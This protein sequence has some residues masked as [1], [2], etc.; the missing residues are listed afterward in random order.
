MTWLSET[1]NKVAIVQGLIEFIAFEELD[2]FPAH[3]A[4]ILQIICDLE[5]FAWPPVELGNTSGSVGEPVGIEPVRQLSK[6]IWGDRHAVAHPLATIK[7]EIV[8]VGLVARNLVLI[9][10]SVGWRDRGAVVGV[11][12]RV[13]LVLVHGMNKGV[14]CLIGRVVPGLPN[15]T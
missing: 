11:T 8:E 6:V 5:A 4:G 10:R 2:T 1:S 12:K 13:E 3:V 15:Q 14:M 7:A 9:D